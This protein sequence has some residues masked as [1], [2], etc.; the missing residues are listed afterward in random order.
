MA[1]YIRLNGRADV[2][3]L[4]EKFDVSK[5]TV[6]RDIDALVEKGLAARA[7]GGVLSLENK[8][9][10]ETPFSAKVAVNSAEKRRIARRAA[11]LVNDNDI[12][13]LDA[14]TTCCELAR[15]LAGEPRRNLTVV[16]HDVL[17][18]YEIACSG[19]A[20]LIVAGGTLEPGVF[21]LTGSGTVDFYRRLHVNR[22]FIGCD[23]IDAEFGMSNRLAGETEIKRAMA[24]CADESYLLFDGSK[25]GKRAFSLVFSPEELKNISGAVTDCREESC[26]ELFARAG[27][28]LT[29][30]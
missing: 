25:F 4:S 6:R 22:A 1:D 14:G 10:Y 9:S 5:V 28:E 27:V 3:E 17:I 13:L 11:A 19:C 16:T 18:A 29:S 8:L 30:C 20:E 23:A 7:H 21:T 15:C 2:G 24:A 12:I 26:R